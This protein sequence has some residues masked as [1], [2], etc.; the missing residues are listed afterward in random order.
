MGSYDTVIEYGFQGN[1]LMIVDSEDIK[2]E[3]V[4]NKD[5]NRG[6]NPGVYFLINK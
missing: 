3:L 6:N 1:M 4:R 2:E 5:C